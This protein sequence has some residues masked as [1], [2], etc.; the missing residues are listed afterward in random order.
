MVRFCEVCAAAK[1]TSM[2]LNK[3]ASDSMFFDLKWCKNWDSEMQCRLNKQWGIEWE[4][5]KRVVEVLVVES[6][7]V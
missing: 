6:N 3:T 2:E 4:R 7:K 5:E 1:Q